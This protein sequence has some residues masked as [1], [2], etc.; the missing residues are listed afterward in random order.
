MKK[1]FSEKGISILE[2]I[3]ISAVVLLMVTNAMTVLYLYQNSKGKENPKI[4]LEDSGNISDTAQESDENVKKDTTGQEDI[5]PKQEEE[6]S[7]AA[8]DQD[9][10]AEEDSRE[11]EIEVAWNEWPVKISAEE[12]FDYR[13]IKLQS[14][15]EK[16]FDG[17]KVYKTGVIKKGAFTGK[18]LYI[19]KYFPMTIATNDNI[20]RVIKDGDKFIVLTNY[21]DPILN[22]ENEGQYWGNYFELFTEN[23]S[24]KIANLDPPKEIKIP[25][26]ELVFLRGDKDTHKF[27]TEYDVKKMFDFGEYSIFKGINENCF[28]GKAH[29]GTAREY[30]FNLD[31]LNDKTKEY[32]FEITPI[33]LKMEWVKGNESEK[34]YTYQKIGGCGAQGCYNYAGYIKSL[35]QLE[36]A[37]QSKSGDIFYELKDK[38]FTLEGAKKTLLREIYDLYFPGWDAATN[39]EKEKISFDEF[40]ADHPV[41]YWQDPFG[42]FIEFRN[43]EYLPGVECGKPVIY[44]YPKKE[45]DISVKVNPTGGFTLTE[46][47]YNNGWM[48]K[49]TPNSE[50]YNYA[51]KTTYPYLF[52]EGHA[53]DYK[54]PDKGFVVKKENVKNFLEEKLAMLGLIKKEY[55][56]F[57]EFW[58]PKMRD[59]NYYFITFVPQEEF[60]NLAPL[61][62]TPR[63]DTVIRVFMDYEGLDAPIKVKEEELTT[64]ARNGFTVVE[65]GG[66]LHR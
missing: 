9:A 36:K 38:D 7:A 39:K 5:A 54:R 26:S 47:A 53:F 21:S 40:I 59:K 51:D 64:P 55:D 28:L 37:G 11:G 15:E 34:E 60:D 6:E 16:F 25:Q 56:E 24:I 42:E 65:W 10:T 19:L 57:I 41:I 13:R 1:I 48:V 14:E 3:L 17:L 29:D 2:T 45:T 30:Y 43:A 66:A 52:W 32:H 4:S 27:I 35:A 44:L 61:N 62:V 46:P 50:I 49:A 23:K 31:F 63:P 18:D 22:S 20:H 33:L 12:F 58:L 8:S